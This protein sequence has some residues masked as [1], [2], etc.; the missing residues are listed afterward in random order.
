MPLS[1]TFSICK[2]IITIIARDVTLETSMLEGFLDNG[3]FEHAN[4]LFEEMPERYYSLEC[5]DSQE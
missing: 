3:E 2:I 4:E 5:D 1:K